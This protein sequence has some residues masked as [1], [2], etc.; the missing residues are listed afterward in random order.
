MQNIVD[1]VFGEPEQIE[2]RFNAYIRANAHISSFLVDFA[3]K[4]TDSSVE[5]MISSVATTVIT[6][7]DND[8]SDPPER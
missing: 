1:F 8:E 7:T 3:A 2:D 6:R 5:W 4:A